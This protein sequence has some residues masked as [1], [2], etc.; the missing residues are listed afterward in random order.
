[1]NL[2]A[3]SNAQANPIPYHQQLESWSSLAFLHLQ[4]HWII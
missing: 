1:M 4:L 2:L 3:I